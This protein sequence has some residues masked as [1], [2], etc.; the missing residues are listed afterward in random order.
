M[1]S[2][3]VATDVPVTGS[4]NRAQACDEMSINPLD[5]VGRKAEKGMFDHFP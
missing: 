2:R 5:S 4:A 3:Q 1:T